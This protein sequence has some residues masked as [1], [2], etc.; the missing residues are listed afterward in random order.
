[1]I[2]K[3]ASSVLPKL[4]GF[5]SQGEPWLKS[6]ECVGFGVSPVGHIPAAWELKNGEQGVFVWLG[7]TVLSGKHRE[8]WV[9]DSEY[10]SVAEQEGCEETL[11][12][13]T[14]LCPWVVI[15][16]PSDE[17]WAGRRFGS[18]EEALTW[19]RHFEW[20]ESWDSLAQHHG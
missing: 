12:L 9:F 13:M 2:I 11:S 20:E 19:L 18:R 4:Q 17:L 1:M 6:W 15:F 10:F 14:S 3:P 7:Q 16:E 8:A 5:W